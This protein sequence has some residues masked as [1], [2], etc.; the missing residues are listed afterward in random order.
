MPEDET[1]SVL[2][3]DFVLTME[4]PASL[5]EVAA[6]QLREAILAGQLPAGMRLIE[7]EV[8]QRF[9]ISRSTLRQAL[10]AL[11]RE[12]LIEIQ[13]NRGTY[14]ADPHPEDIEHM[15][16]LRGLI[17]GA[18]A[19]L[20]AARRDPQSLAR[21]RTVLERQRQ[22]VGG[23]D[24]EGFI[25]L[26][27][28]FHQGICEEAGN[29]FILQSWTVLGNTIRLYYRLVMNIR[30]AVRDNSFYL[31]YLEQESPDAAEEL[32]RGQLL[33]RAYF[34]LKKPIP[35]SVVPYVRRYVDSEGRIQRGHP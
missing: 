32:V 24:R 35:P 15:S 18:A 33:N 30:T 4:R 22:A 21:L 34:H 20:V 27:W 25:G 23:E 17:E 28:M 2:G 13:K 16:L 10:H 7:A 19:R 1:K 3:S 9:G 5:A 31:Q 11:S 26:H 29:P 6:K 14:V 12:G 8:S